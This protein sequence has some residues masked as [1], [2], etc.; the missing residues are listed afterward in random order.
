[1]TDRHS[2]QGIQG[3]VPPGDGQGDLSQFLP[4]IESAVGNIEP[5]KGKVTGLE[6]SLR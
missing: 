4:A 1:M 5:I 6:I 3:I 2:R